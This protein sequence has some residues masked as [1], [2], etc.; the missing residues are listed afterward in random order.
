MGNATYKYKVT[1]L[2]I[3]LLLL[4]SSIFAEDP[5]VFDAEG[6]NQ[7][8]VVMEL[9]LNP[10]YQNAL[11]A[12]TNFTYYPLGT[13]VNAGKFYN[14][15]PWFSSSKTYGLSRTDMMYDYDFDFL[16]QPKDLAG[17]KLCMSLNGKHYSNPM[18]VSIIGI[19]ALHTLNTGMELHL[20]LVQY[21]YFVQSEEI[22]EGVFP[23]SMTK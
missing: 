15:H 6:L 11:V 2:I 3:A 5:I 18:K 8:E 19:N 7:D 16:F 12:I 10:D 17:Q 13:D 9:L 1:T 21:L 4:S 23:P 14:A 20:F 22:F